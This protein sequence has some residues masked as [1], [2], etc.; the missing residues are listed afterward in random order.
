MDHL[1][2]VTVNDQIFPHIAHGYTD[3][4]PAIREL[5]V[6]VRWTEGE[7]GSLAEIVR[8]EFM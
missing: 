7:R 5:T 4:V 1:L 2:P 3:T 6:K 8:Q